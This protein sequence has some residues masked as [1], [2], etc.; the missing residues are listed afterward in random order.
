MLVKG[1]IGL[2]DRSSINEHKYRL[3]SWLSDST[4]R[5]FIGVIFTF[6]KEASVIYIV[7]NDFQTWSMIV[8]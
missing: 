6:A 3:V 8:W 5:P 2:Q 4:G 1:A 7:N